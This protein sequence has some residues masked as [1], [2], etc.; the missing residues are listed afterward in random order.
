MLLYSFTSLINGCYPRA[1]QKVRLNVVALVGTM[2]TMLT[3]L[4]SGSPEKLEHLHLC[5]LSFQKAK[6]FQCAIRFK[7]LDPLAGCSQFIETND[8]TVIV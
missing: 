4:T 5:V 7:P 1:G 3:M 6:R 2:L 8:V